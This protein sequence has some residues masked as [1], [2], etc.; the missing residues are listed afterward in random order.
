MLLL[1][2]SADQNACRCEF[3]AEWPIGNHDSTS[4]LL[5]RFFPW[6]QASRAA[7]DRTLGEYEWSR[8]LGYIPHMFPF[9]ENPK[10]WRIPEIQP[11][12]TTGM[13]F[14]LTFAIYHRLIILPTLTTVAG[15]LDLPT[16]FRYWPHSYHPNLLQV[17]C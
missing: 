6:S 8:L 15:Q 2:A 3:L 14:E 4:V 17:P 10:H 11:P 12:A 5:C 9:R 7:P 13:R 1:Q 16:C